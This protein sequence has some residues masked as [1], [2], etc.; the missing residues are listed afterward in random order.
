[1]QQRAGARAD[2]DVASGVGNSIGGAH[3][4][5]VT[6]RFDA[7]DFQVVED[8]DGDAVSAGLLRQFDELARQLVVVH[9]ASVRG[10]ERDD[11][12]LRVTS[13]HHHGFDLGDVIGAQKPDVR[14]VFPELV[15]AK[16]ETVGLAIDGDDLLLDDHGA[17][18]QVAAAEPLQEVRTPLDPQGALE[19]VVRLDLAAVQRLAVVGHVGVDLAG[20][21]SAFDD[22]DPFGIGVQ[23]KEPGL[24]CS[25]HACAD[26]DRVVHLFL[27]RHF[28]R[29]ADAGP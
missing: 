29:V 5:S 22:Q 19:I 3:D 1:M 10:V 25:R 14:E 24:S 9:R 26:D 6:G 4:E 15:E 16:L 2:A 20:L 23:G 8:V 17:V 12:L 7:L 21:L 11:V 28:G 27:L 18:G 13:L